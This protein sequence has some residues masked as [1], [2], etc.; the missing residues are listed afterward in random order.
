MIALPR[1]QTPIFLAPMAGGFNTPEL[2]AAVANAGGVGS[3]G[4]AYSSPEAIDRSLVVASTQTTGL[5]NANFFVFPEVAAPQPDRV[6]AALHALNAILPHGLLD[7][8]VLIPPYVPDLATQ[9]EPVWQR[10][11]AMVTFHFGIPPIAL[12]EQ[13]HALGIT[14]GITA[15]CV[16]EAT[17]IAAAGADFVVA[18]GWEA[19]GHRGCFDTTEMDQ[20]QDLLALVQAMAKHISLP[21]V[22]AGGLMTGGDIATVLSAGATAA[23]LGTA[24]LC[25]PEANASA[26]H[27]ALLLAKEPRD[28][29][30]TSAFS[31]R[32][33]R[34][35]QNRF[36][37]VMRGKEL[38]EFPLQNSLTAAL[39]QW[40]LQHENAEFQSVWA[41]SRYRD[42]RPLPA[43]R[44]MQILNGEIKVA[45]SD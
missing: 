45:L 14:V 30:F 31:G 20:E 11:P 40:A 34:G 37:D 3:F 4:F 35:I 44:L 33:A 42:I 19:G 13:A 39:R 7:E 21:I 1:L 24:F 15:T 9:L 2:V 28:T 17:Q 32:S 16:A 43:A 6:A 5:I 22:A 8:S 29:V 25:C 38:L 12:I 36:I 10:R 41:G 26:S 27:R 23:Q 18:Q